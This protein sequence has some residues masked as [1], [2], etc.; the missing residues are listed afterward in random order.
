MTPE[1]LLAVLLTI[2]DLRIGT[3]NL[4]AE[5]AALR[6]RVAELEAEGTRSTAGDP[7]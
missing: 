3:A 1:Q 5:N 2:A 4:Q 7:D 6:Q